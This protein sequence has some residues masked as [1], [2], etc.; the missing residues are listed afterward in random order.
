M[1]RESKVI[2]KVIKG[3]LLVTTGASMAALK[4][5]Q[6][7]RATF[8]LTEQ[9][10]DAISIVAN[11]LGIKQKSLFDHLLEDT[12]LLESIAREIEDQPTVSQDRRQKTYV[13]SRNS[14]T[15]INH[16][17]EHYAAPRDGLIELIMR[18]LL[19][20]IAREKKRYEK[21]KKALPEIEA[22]FNEG[23]KLFAKL[24]TTLGPDDILTRRFIQAIRNHGAI[25]NEIRALMAKA[26]ALEK[27][28]T[29]EPEKNGKP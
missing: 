5:R 19:P 13:I 25:F 23:Q 11:Q 18:R 12:E 3:S 29:R 10:I 27:F 26:E 4:G 22:F 14:L 17:A 24:D 28:D 1:D 20:I 8:K 15:V 2:T 16:I 6:S 7:V 9:C 21:R